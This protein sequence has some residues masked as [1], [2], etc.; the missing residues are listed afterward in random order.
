MKSLMMLILTEVCTLARPL[1]KYSHDEINYYQLIH[2]E[3]TVA[4]VLSAWRN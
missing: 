1:A 2:L 3:S 4:A